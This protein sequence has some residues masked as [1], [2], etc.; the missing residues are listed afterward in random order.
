MSIGIKDKP[1]HVSYDDEY[2]STLQIISKRH[3][4]FYDII[5][6]QAWLLDGASALLHPLRSFIKYSQTKFRLKDLVIFENNELEELN[7]SRKGGDA[8][9]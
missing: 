7:E 9:F 4:V 2:L 8:A 6:R 1:K 5:D 3:F